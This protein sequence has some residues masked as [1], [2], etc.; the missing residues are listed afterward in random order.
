[1][2]TDKKSV[3]NK[4]K[5]TNWLPTA[6]LVLLV[7]LLIGIFYQFK[8]ENR[9]AVVTFYGNGNGS[10]QSKNYGLTQFTAT[11]NL[12]SS[13]LAEKGDLLSYNDIILLFDKAKKD[14][15]KVDDSNN[16]FVF[17][18]GK[19]NSIIISE[20]VDLLPWL[21]SM[22]PYAIS[23]LKMIHFQS[24]IKNSYIPYLKKIA[25]LKPNTAL[26]FEENDSLNVMKSY[27][28]KSDFFTPEFIVVQL[29]ER[30]LPLLAHWKTTKNLY[31]SMSDS[32]ISNSLPAMPNL[33]QCVLSGIN[34][35]SINPIFFDQ[36]KQ[37]KKLSIIGCP[38]NY[39][40][41]EPLPNLEQLAISQYDC[42]DYT[43]NLETIQNKLAN[44]SVLILSGNHTNI[45]ILSK[46]KNLH[47]LG[48][49][50]N[51]SQKEFDSI[52]THLQNL[53]VI[54]LKGSPAIKDLSSLKKL[55]TLRAL[56][57]RDTITDKKTLLALTELRYLSVPKT[58]MKD[59]TYVHELEK[60]LPGCILVP[61]SGA[62]VGSG[63]L[64]LLIP[65]VFLFSVVFNKKI[66]KR[67][68][69]KNPKL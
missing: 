48:L 47:W 36:N 12:K 42:E 1:M 17:V 67:S 35:R 29:P 2:D 43:N 33:K 3:T 63:W 28:K 11:K 27:L 10:N 9:F 61:N 46:Y 14:S 59:S 53:Q 62:C 57:I 26:S 30:Q 18:N 68:F 60:A 37:L 32:I 54:E 25:H 52:A 15:L 56:V 22:D 64:L 23:D 41:L 20:K 5:R 51:T 19:I 39:T 58:N 45:D 7:I 21:R 16:S 4:P 34:I 24:E 65:L 69:K 6:L 44:L 38:R 13:V 55:P 31:I 40:F 66:L 50:S 8:N 49:P